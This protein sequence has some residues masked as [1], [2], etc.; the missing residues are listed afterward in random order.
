[1][2]TRTAVGLGTHSKKGGGPQARKIALVGSQIR[3]HHDPGFQASR[4]MRKNTLLLFKPP[5]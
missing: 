2:C 4:S 3:R 1:M 5:V